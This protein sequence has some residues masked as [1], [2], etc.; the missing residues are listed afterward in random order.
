[1]YKL[2]CIG[3]VHFRHVVGPRFFLGVCFRP[4]SNR[5]NSDLNKS[6]FQHGGSLNHCTLG[7]FGKVK[8]NLQI[9]FHVDQRGGW[10]TSRKCC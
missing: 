2:S 7:L 4:R 10:K 3:T 1:M 5:C 8:K 6:C 9:F